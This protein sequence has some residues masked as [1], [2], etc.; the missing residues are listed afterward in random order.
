MSQLYHTFPHPLTLPLTYSCL[1]LLF[2]VINHPASPHLPR[3]YLLSLILSPFLLLRFIPILLLS[4]LPSFLLLFIPILLFLFIHPSLLPSL[5]LSCSGHTPFHKIFRHVR[6]GPRSSGQRPALLLALLYCTQLCPI[7]TQTLKD[8]L[9]WHI[10]LVLSSFVP[11]SLVHFVTPIDQPVCHI[12]GTDLEP[13]TKQTH[14][15][16]C[17]HTQTIY[18]THSDYLFSSRVRSVSLRS[19]WYHSAAYLAQGT[20]WLPNH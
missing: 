19:T 17:I 10:T 8:D 9:L 4:F 6:K 1:F 15:H 5:L 13:W 18:D 14:V 16:T 3:P 11:L 12:D 7:S 2:L 20:G